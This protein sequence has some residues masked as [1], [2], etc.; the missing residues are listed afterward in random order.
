MCAV[1]VECLFIDRSRPAPAGA[2]MPR[3]ITTATGPRNLV[4]DVTL[5]HVF[6]LLTTLQA[7]LALLLFK[8]IRARFDQHFWSL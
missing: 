5:F 6:K 3:T 8:D 1:C 7:N 4:I 2:F